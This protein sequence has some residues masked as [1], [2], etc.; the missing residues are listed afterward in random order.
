ML[1]TTAATV[2]SSP[3]FTGAKLPLKPMH[4]WG[5]RVRLQVE[6]RLR[7]LALFDIALDSKLRGCDVVSL[8]VGD[9]ISGGAPRKRGMVLQQK[10][11]RPVQFEITEQTRQSIARLLDRRAGGLEEWLFPSRLNLERHLSTRQCHES[12]ESRF[13]LDLREGEHDSMREALTEPRLERFIGVIYRPETEHWSHYSA[14]ILPKQFDAWVWFDETSAVTP[15]PT[16]Q[17]EGAEETY[18]FGL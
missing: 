18:P 3:K 5:I 17:L 10:T 15:L 8:R 7:D 6:K 1:D 14:A 9:V 2:P 12:G 11:G 13:L 16:E 4:V